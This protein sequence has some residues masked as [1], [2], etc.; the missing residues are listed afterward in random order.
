LGMVWEAE[1]NAPRAEVA[2]RRALQLAPDHAPA[3]Y[4]LA[5]LLL[6]NWRTAEADSHLRT[7]LTQQPDHANALAIRGQ[8]HQTQGQVATGL[9]WLR[10]SLALARNATNHSKLLAALQYDERSTPASLL[11]EHRQWESAYA[12]PLYDAPLAERPHG[13]RERLRLGF[14]SADFGMHPVSSIL[15]AAVEHLDRTQCFVACY[16]DR[17]RNDPDTARFRSAADLW[18]ETGLLNDADLARQ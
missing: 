10:R 3:R 4:A 15:R 9:D 5:V 6:N 11:A 13:P 18:R 8:T 12:R 7:L 17:P 1:G 16:C 2:Y 14:L